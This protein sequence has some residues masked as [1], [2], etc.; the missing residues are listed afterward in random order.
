MQE[1]TSMQYLHGGR[2]LRAVEQRE[3][4]EAAARLDSGDVLFAAVAAL[5]DDGEAAAFDDVEVVAAFTWNAT[6]IEANLM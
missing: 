4:A 1:D 3:L 2:P 5:D 6:T